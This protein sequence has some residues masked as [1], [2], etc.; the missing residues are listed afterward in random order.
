MRLV[1]TF[2]M[3]LVSAAGWAVEEQVVTIESQGQKVVGTLVLPDGEPA[4]VVLLLHGFTGSRDELETEHV[5]EGIFGR[6]AARL[7]EKGYSSLR[8]D[9]RG[10]GESIAGIDFSQT[11]FEGQIADGHAAISYLKNQPLVDGDEL[12]ILGWSQGGLVAS[13]LA[14]RGSAIDAVALWAAVAEPE[15]T[16]GHLLGAETMQLGKAAKPDE[17]VPIEL[18][19]GAKMTL[20]GAFFAGVARFDPATEIASYAGP[21]FVAQGVEDTIVMPRA[22]ELLIAAHEG[23][24]E[25]W[26]ADMDHVFNSFSSAERLEE[27]IA[28]T[29][30]FFDHHDD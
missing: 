18:P 21:L 30:K 9:F 19:W 3:L 10:S 11:T 6:T 23:P 7:A 15:Q 16:Y 14:G 26:M 2:F 24:E 27:L 12:H 25:F 28:R 13:A 29:V 1:L 8:I 5:A 20:N 17:A 22:A 4:P